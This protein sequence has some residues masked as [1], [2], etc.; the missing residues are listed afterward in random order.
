M[1]FLGHI[2]KIDNNSV[3]KLINIYKKSPK[4]FD[5]YLKKK[6]NIKINQYYY[7]VNDESKPTNN[8]RTR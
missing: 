1:E 4:I 2:H 7:I 3:D 8:D 6:Y 5:L